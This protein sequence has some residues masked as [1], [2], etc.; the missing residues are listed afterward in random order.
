MR[1]YGCFSDAAG[2]SEY[3]EA[4]KQGSRAVTVLMCIDLSAQ[5]SLTVQ[6]FF[7]CLFVWVFFLQMLKTQRSVVS[8]NLGG[9]MFQSIVTLILIFA[10]GMAR[11]SVQVCQILKGH[12][13]N[14][15][16][17][18]S[19]F[20]MCPAPPLTGVVSRCNVFYLYRFP[21]YL[22]QWHVANLDNF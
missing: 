13:K 7:V 6:S 5:G 16:L 22:M 10:F 17:L 21:S 20:Q 3:G 9:A 19:N 14:P 11:L 12:F 15:A 1:P 2:E 4:L 18:V 8:E